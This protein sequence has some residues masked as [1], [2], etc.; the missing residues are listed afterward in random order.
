MTGRRAGSR[1]GSGS[2]RLMLGKRSSSARFAGSE[3]VATTS[4]SMKDILELRPGVHW[5]GALHPEL[6]VFDDLFP[7]EHGT[8][9]NSYLIRGAEKVA[10]VDTVKEKFS[11]PFLG[12]VRQLVEPARVDYVIVNHSEP[13]HSGSLPALLQHCPNATV[14]CSS[15]AAAFL[16]NQ[17]DF[18]FKTRS[19]KDGEVLDLGGR[20]LR[21]VIAPFLHWPDTMFTLLEEERILFTC[22]AFGAHYCGSGMYDDEVPDFTA[23]M[24]L[25]YDCLVRPFKDKVLSAIDKIRGERIDVIAPSHGPI[26]RSNPGRAVA[27]YEEWSR[28][29]NGAG[30]AAAGAGKVVILYLSPHGNTARMSEAVAAGAAQPGVEV[31]RRHIGEIGDAQVRDLMEAAD[32]LVFGVPTVNRDVPKPVWDVLALLSTVNLKTSV[33]GVFGSYGWSGEACKMVEDRLKG[34]RF[35]LPIPLVRTQFR[36]SPGVLAECQA[37]G[38]AIAAEVLKAK[39]RTGAVAPPG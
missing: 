28:Q 2:S 29:R 34:L 35:T 23:D 16:R 26:L 14:L 11:E 22:D 7:T 4:T 31:I 19:V 8:T 6:R 32:A 13:D 5:I 21:F 10:I 17:I 15:T 20:R 1:D 39:G 33:A 24:K 30:P 18:P 37:L 3:H 36:P 12:K 25:Y 38:K 27:L 9:Y